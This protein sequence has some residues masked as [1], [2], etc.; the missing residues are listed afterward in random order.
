MSRALWLDPGFGASGDML[1]G[2]LLGLGAPLEAVRADVAGLGV[3]GW[4]IDV[5]PVLRAGIAATRAVVVTDDHDQPDHGPHA[6]ASHGDHDH[7]HDDHDHGDGG[8]EPGRAEHRAWSTIDRLLA[9]AAL[10]ER[11]KAGARAT[12]ELLGRVEAGIHGVAIDEVHFHEV[13]ALDAIVDI[14]GAWSA[15]HHLGIDEVASG[16]VGIGNGVIQAAHGRLPAP[17]PATVELLAGAAA[18]RPV[19]WASETVT[20]TGAALLR[21]MVTRWGPVPAGRLVAFSRG[22]GGRNPATHPNVLGALLVEVDEN[23]A[24]GASGLSTRPRTE[25][26][27]VLA[28]NLDDVTAELLGHLVTRLLDAGADDAWV[29]PIGMK[30]NR[31]GHELRVLCPPDRAEGLEALIFAETGTLG[32]RRELV[33]K[34]VLERSWRTVTVRGHE[35]R[36]KRGP[37]GAKAEHDDVAA[38]SRATGLPL[39]LL[40]AEAVTAADGEDPA[41]HRPAGDQPHPDRQEPAAGV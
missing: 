38:A 13:G 23:L 18:I 28:T 4:S 35:I 27:L 33:A 16:P 17:A 41:E 39:R 32:L 1:L 40:G 36:V 19:E 37:Y 8:R 29:V 21:T 20:P 12:F 5:E 9:G 6:H 2:T 14:V 11:V 30:K 15:L 31:P 10:P 26:A 25:A 3:T 7:D 22:A 24:A 34:Q